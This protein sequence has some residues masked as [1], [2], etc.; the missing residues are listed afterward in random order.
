MKKILL[1]FSL[2]FSMNSFANDV[3]AFYSG[4][5]IYRR[6]NSSALQDQAFSNGYIMGAVDGFIDTLKKDKC[7]MKDVQA[8]QIIDTVKKYFAENPNMRQYSAQSSVQVAFIRGF[9]R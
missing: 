3:A 7:N 2:I 4:N 5:E 1:I 9:C 6:L 8:Q